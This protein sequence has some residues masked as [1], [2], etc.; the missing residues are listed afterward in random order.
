M[1]AVVVGCRASTTQTHS[2]TTANP[3]LLRKV[4]THTCTIASPPGLDPVFPLPLL[5]KGGVA[6]PPWLTAVHFGP[7]SLIQQYRDISTCCT[8]TLGGC[9]A[10]QAAGC[11]GSFLPAHPPLAATVWVLVLLSVWCSG[12]IGMCILKGEEG[13]QGR[14]RVRYQTSTVSTVLGLRLGEG[15]AAVPL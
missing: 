4:G 11:F 15:D 1:V 14:K 13:K 9:S 3:S 5:Q 2:S 12:Q 10:W 7:Q 8:A 6:C